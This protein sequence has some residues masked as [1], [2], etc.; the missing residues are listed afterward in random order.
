[1]P[2]INEE[3]LKREISLKNLAPVYLLFGDD[4][5]LK[6]HY[7]KQIEK[8]ADIGDPFF[9]L[10]KFET[11]ANLQD[12]FD[13]VNQYPMMSDKKVVVLSD[14][15]FETASKS[16]FDKLCE[17]L[18]GAVESCVLIVKFD[19][20]E[21]D[22]KSAKAKKLIDAAEKGGGKAVEL[23]SRN[24]AQLRKMLRDGAQKR[25]CQI[26]DK[27]ADYIIESVGDDINTLRNELD[28][29]CAYKSNSEID[30]GIIDLVCTKSVEAS[31]YD[32]AK[33]IIAGNISRALELL[34]DMFF[35]RFEPMIILHTVSSTYIDMYRVAAG[36]KA[37]KK[38]GEIGAEMGYPK[39][40]LF[41][42]DNAQYN[43]KKFD[44][45]KL[46][47]SFEALLHAD[48]QLKSFGTDPRTVLE[49]LTVKLVY[50]M[51]KGESVD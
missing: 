35:M 19:G 9:N 25:G 14:Y 30:T 32:Y 50:I 36:Q 41:V 16:D 17:L 42:L 23:G 22:A 46:N 47:L 15:Q 44:A 8:K 40:R 10:Q 49:Q 27:V 13:A 45:N 34:D 7:T 51:T 5:F 3:A 18:K 4:S 38:N 29:L 20:V 21:F 48:K 37:G 28:K 43:L 26:S 1:M 31:I 2:I 12:V 11:D 33:Q 6:T 24:R 39:N